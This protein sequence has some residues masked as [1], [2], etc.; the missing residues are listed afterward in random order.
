MPSQQAAVERVA[1]E[2]GAARAAQLA[3]QTGAVR[4]HRAHREVQLC[5]DL[6]VGVAQGEEPQD[7][8]LALGEVVRRRSGLP[9]ADRPRAAV[10]AGRSSSRQAAAPAWSAWRTNRASSFVASTMTRV[11]GEACSTAR[12][13]S[14]DEMSPGRSRSRTSAAGVWR[15]TASTAASA[16]PASATTSSPA[17]LSSVAAQLGANARV[18]GRQHDDDRRVALARQEPL[19]LSPRTSRRA[20]RHYG[21]FGGDGLITRGG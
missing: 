12:M 16:S 10:L 9:A 18:A 19:A 21:R 11:A 6:G 2:L 7:V 4:L 15:A 8:E 14:S 13:V 17:A 20:S 1:H 3:L 5:G